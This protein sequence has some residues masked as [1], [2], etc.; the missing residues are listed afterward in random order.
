MTRLQPSLPGIPHAG[1]NPNAATRYLVS[2]QLGLPR[3]GLQRQNRLID[4]FLKRQFGSFQIVLRLQIYPYQNAHA[5]QLC[6]FPSGVHRDRALAR[7]DFVDAALLD[8][9]EF[10]TLQPVNP[11][12]SI[13]SFCQTEWNSIRDCAC[14]LVTHT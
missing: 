5:K 4:L 14:G 8:V 3:R 2:I 9:G 11:I 12:G 7:A 6:P 1:D 13:K 10:V